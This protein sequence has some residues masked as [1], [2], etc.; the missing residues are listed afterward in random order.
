MICRQRHLGVGNGLVETKCGQLELNYWCTSAEIANDDTTSEKYFNHI[1][2]VKKYY[3]MVA[4][5]IDNFSCC[6]K[7]K[8]WWRQLFGHTMSQEH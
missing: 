5:I 8:Y 4:Y 7:F 2:T 1:L 3:T 6:W